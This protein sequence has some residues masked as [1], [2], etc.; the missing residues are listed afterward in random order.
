[1]ASVRRAVRAVKADTVG[2]VDVGRREPE[3]P[4]AFVAAGDDAVD[5]DVRDAV[6]HVV[7]E[8]FG[9]HALAFPA[10][11][12]PARPAAAITRRSS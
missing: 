2:G 10:H 1:M 8:Q 3:L 7:G 4:S 11:R 5:N 12:D 9:R 6:G